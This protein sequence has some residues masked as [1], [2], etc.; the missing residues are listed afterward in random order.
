MNPVALIT[1][2]SRGIGRGIALALAQLGFDLVIHYARE[3]EA[4]RESEAL[5]R[6]AAERAQKK[7]T[8]KACQADLAQSANR[9]AL[10]DFT[11]REFGRL[12]LLVNNAGVAP[13]ERRDLLE[14]SEESLD[15]LLAINLKGPFFLTQL[16]AQ[17]MIAQAREDGGIGEGLYSPKI[18]LISS[19]SAY[20]V[21]LNRAEYC[22][23]K[24]ALSMVTPLY[25]ARLAEEGIQ[26]FEIRPGIMRTDMT[27]P[28]KE[29]YDR[30]IQSG[31]TPIAR[32]GQPK[33]VGSAVAA[34]AQ[35]AFPFSTGEV[36]NVDGG[37][38]L[39]RL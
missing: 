11:R 5:C 22:L 10:I 9:A 8:V 20:T 12:N 38:H 6:G 1:G 23:S 16:A 26:V 39:R 33:D 31:L 35:N 2:S 36:F 21:S 37:F 14:T 15:R 24:A 28:V 17:W 25:A 29:K 18:I 4:A 30:L 32:W 34:I 19:I 7:I 13:L 3:V 27:A